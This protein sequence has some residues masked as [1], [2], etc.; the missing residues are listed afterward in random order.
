MAR[1]L[2]DLAV[3]LSRAPAS[4]RAGQERGVARS[5]GYVTN[6][7][8]DDTRRDTGGDSR[9][10]GVGK[11]GARVGARYRVSG[12]GAAAKAYIRALGPYQ[13]LERDTAAHFMVP[14][15]WRV[16]KRYGTAVAKG[17]TPRG[18]MFLAGSRA[19]KFKGGFYTTA[20]HPGTRG[21]HTFERAWKRAA[22]RT[23]EIFG[24]EVAAALQKGW[25]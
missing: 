11:S 13:L 12:T 25:A 8:R 21:K 9:L 5:A 16:S 7:I 23:T 14:R 19:L 22:P 1:T 6:V 4:I 20:E 15:G 10:S 18:P 24:R 3:S 2:G 17:R